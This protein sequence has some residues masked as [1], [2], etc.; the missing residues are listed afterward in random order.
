[1]PTEP[2]ENSDSHSL[3]DAPKATAPEHGTIDGTDSDLTPSKERFYHPEL[4]GLRFFAFLGVFI[5]HVVPIA[6]TSIPQARSSVSHA[7]T[8]ITSHAGEWGVDLFFL[9]SAYLITELLLREEDQYGKLDWYSFYVRRSLRIWPLYFVFI[10]AVWFIEPVAFGQR[11]SPTDFLATCAVF[12]GNWSM[13][14]GPEFH[15]P[16]SVLWT[17]SIEEQFYLMWP[18]LLLLFGRKRIGILVTLMLTV[19]FVS[20]SLMVEAGASSALIHFSTL[21]R[22]D[23]IAVGALIAWYFHDRKLPKLNGLI[24]TGLIA[25][26]VGLWLGIVYFIDVHRVVTEIH[27]YRIP[28]ATVGA[29]LIFFGVLRPQNEPAGWLSSPWL[30]YLGR[31]SYGLYIWHYLMVYLIEYSMTQSG[32]PV[33]RPVITIL[34]LIATINIAAI[35]YKF[36][37]QPF[38]RLKTRFARVSSRPGG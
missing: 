3:Y 30:V 35:S 28:L 20:R 6:H 26:G 34:S 1:M 24:R 21:T 16:T 32:I 2:V 15:A 11:L 4:D 25:A 8:Y 27:L 7:L 36:I 37:E 31:I 38:L 14:L 13:A 22:L 9:L 17:V 12:L 29:A 10:V 19:A 33:H 18:L 23:G 5:Y